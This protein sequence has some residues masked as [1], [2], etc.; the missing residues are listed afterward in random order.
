MTAAER[1][2]LEAPPHGDAPEVPADDRGLL[3]GDGL[4]DTLRLYRGRPFRLEQHLDRL[5]RGAAVVGIDV[6]ADLRLRVDTAIRSW[7]GGDGALR[8]TLTRGSGSGLAP[9]GDG[10]SRLLVSIR[11]LSGDGGQSASKGIH[12]LLR[13]RVDE[14]ALVSGLKTIG[15]LE[16]IQALRLAMAQGADEALLRNSRDRVVEASASNVAAVLGS[17]LV[18]PGPP[19]GALGGITR[20]IVLGEAE[21]MGMLIEERGLEPDELGEVSEILLTSSV[22]EIV[23]VVRVEGLAVGSGKPGPLLEEMRDRLRRRVEAELF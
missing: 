22:R 9:P 23:P 16:R 13:G 18:A 11:G 20:S 12:A 14:C 19:D 5:Q 10:R 3:L 1:H 7:S 21:A 15:Y 6:P 17:G 2:P 4:F 8:I